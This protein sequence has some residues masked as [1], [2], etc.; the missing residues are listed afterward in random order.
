MFLLLTKTISALALIEDIRREL[1]AIRSPRHD[2]HRSGSQ[3]GH[4][5]TVHT[6][7]H[8]VTKLYFS[9]ARNHRFVNTPLVHESRSLSRTRPPANELSA[10]S[11]QVRCAKR[12]LKTTTQSL[13]SAN[14]HSHTKRRVFDFRIAKI[15]FGFFYIDLFV[16]LRDDREHTTTRPPVHFTSHRKAANSCFTTSLFLFTACAHVDLYMCA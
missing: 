5:V 3:N 8:E 7:A 16:T 12:Q 14:K 2:C 13:P 11:Q 9:L 6:M 15:L 1:P 4:Y 10:K